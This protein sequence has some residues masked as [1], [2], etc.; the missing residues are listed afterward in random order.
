[1]IRWFFA[2]QFAGA[3]SSSIST[4]KL[5]VLRANMFS[6]KPSRT[7]SKSPLWFPKISKFSIH[8]DYFFTEWFLFSG[9]TRRCKISCTNWYPD[10]ITKRCAGEGNF[11]KNILNM[12]RLLFLAARLRRTC[13]S[14]AS[15][16]KI[17]RGRVAKPYQSPPRFFKYTR[18]TS[19]VLYLRILY[20]LEIILICKCF[21][22]RI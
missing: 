18:V 22:Q 3:V 21:I 2:V 9:R 7:S 11:T 15:R 12:V 20:F 8:E 1:M 16:I 4:G 5:T 10:C 14:I 13:I 19:H 6:T 17:I